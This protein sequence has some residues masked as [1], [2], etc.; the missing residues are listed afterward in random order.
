MRY[1]LQKAQAQFTTYSILF[2]FSDAFPGS[3]LH[4]ARRIFF[5]QHVL[6]ITLFL[7][8]PLFLISFCRDI[9]RRFSLLFP[10][11]HDPEKLLH[12]VIRDLSCKL[13]V[14]LEALAVYSK[15][16]RYALRKDICVSQ[17]K[18]RLLDIS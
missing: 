17:R 13:S 14:Q 18:L 11:H 6:A 12:H 15:V 1:I 7:G 8:N 10:H 4:P 3:Q 16:D 2:L 9:H 5:D